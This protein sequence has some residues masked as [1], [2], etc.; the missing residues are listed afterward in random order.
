IGTFKVKRASAGQPVKSMVTLP[1]AVPPAGSMPSMTG[2]AFGA[3]TT[4]VHAAPAVWVSVNDP[5]VTS[6]AGVAPALETEIDQTRAFDGPAFAA[7]VPLIALVPSATAEM[8]HAWLFRV[9]MSAPPD[10]MEQVCTVEGAPGRS[11]AA[12]EM[13]G[14]L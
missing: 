6:K 7:M 12:T 3:V 5:R 13:G 10:T 1:V 9:L 11:G 2:N 8:S 14:K 4:G